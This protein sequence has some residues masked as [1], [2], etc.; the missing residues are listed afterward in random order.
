MIS[1]AS[2][3][4]SRRR[5]R[6]SNF[7]KIN[8]KAAATTGGHNNL[9]RISH[10]C[11]PFLRQVTRAA[12]AGMRVHFLTRSQ[13]RRRK[14]LRIALANGSGLNDCVPLA[15]PVPQHAHAQP[16]DESNAAPRDP[17]QTGRRPRASSKTTHEYN[18]PIGRTAHEVWRSA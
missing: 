4:A 7:T 2:V 6:S 10:G 18:R 16:I 3:S 8:V 11:P 13:R 15:M 5:S 14:Q 9:N 1:L 12:S 17:D